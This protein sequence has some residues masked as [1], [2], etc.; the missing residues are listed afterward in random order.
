MTKPA[1][2]HAKC[3]ACH[4]PFSILP[5]GKNAVFVKCRTSRC[6]SQKA[7]SG[8]WAMKTTPVES[9]AERLANVVREEC[10]L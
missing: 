7:H 6:P 2:T 10:G 1:N 4:Q 9:I 8:D 3:P 5:M